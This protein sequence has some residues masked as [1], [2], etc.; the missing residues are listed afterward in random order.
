MSVPMNGNAC[1]LERGLSLWYGLS[2]SKETNATSDS[3]YP[4]SASYDR[5]APA[6]ER[7]G[8]AT[9]LTPMSRTRNDMASLN[10]LPPFWYSRSKATMGS[11]PRPAA[12]LQTFL[13][14]FLYSDRGSPRYGTATTP[15]PASTCRRSRMRKKDS[16]FSG[17]DLR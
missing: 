1:I 7:P 17:L 16:I 6:Y 15:R 2:V 4:A 11:A 13:T 10:L 3:A 14:V 8:N 5:A 12:A 9:S